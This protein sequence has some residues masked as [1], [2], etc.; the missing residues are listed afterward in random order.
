[1]ISV[2]VIL[3]DTPASQQAAR[4]AQGATQ[5]ERVIRSL[6]SQAEAAQQGIQQFLQD[7]RN[8]GK[9][10]KEQHFWLINGFSLQATAEVIQALAARPDVIRVFTEETFQAPAVNQSVAAGWDNL[11]K[12]NAP[13]LWAMG[14]RG[15]GMVVASMDTGVDYTHPELA[16]QWRGGTNSWFDPYGNH[17][18]PADLPSTCASRGHGTATMGV[19]VGKT[20]GVAPDAQWIAVKVFDDNCSATTTGIILGFQWLL[21]PDGNPSTPDAPQ[22]VNSSWGGSNPGCGPTDPTGKYVFQPALQN[23]RAAGILPVF[24]A[25][26]SGAQGSD[27]ST[28][29]GNYLEAFPVGATDS[30]DTVAP[31]SSRG[32]NNCI[33]PPLTYPELSAPGVSIYTTGVGNTYTT[34]NGTSF[35]APHVAGGLALL[36]SAFPTGLSV[37]QQENALVS[38]ALDLGPVGPDDSY[39]YGRL[40][41]LSAY[42]WVVGHPDPILVTSTLSPAVIGESGGSV[43][44]NL[45]LNQASTLPI[46]VNFTAS[47]GT[48]TEG[49]DYQLPGQVIIDSGAMQQTVTIPILDDFLPETDET[50]KIHLTLSANA[51]LASPQDVSVVIQD[52][53]IQ[54]GFAVTDQVVNETNGL[55]F[56]NLNRTGGL[57]YPAA[58]DYSFTGGT[59]VS[60]VDYLGLP[61]RI[62]FAAGETLTHISVIL[63]DD[64]QP[65]P[66]KTLTVSLSSPDPVSIHLASSGTTVTILDTGPWLILLPF[67]TR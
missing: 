54:V 41:V 16:A 58:V 38:S 52:D 65:G 8:S 40:D 42:Q 27:T 49:A 53:D 22:V 35:A 23:L 12:I 37:Q 30:L 24:S 67:V 43:S 20:V 6:Q 59:A 25:G 26:N 55:T 63:L 56:I 31:F 18:N 7:N 13:A 44:L 48:A 62:T 17:P 32:P 45:S 29:P 2:I 60:E 50:I 64:K 11:G 46:R 39:G 3:K 19:M 61:G 14:Y 5:A 21:D 66:N 15:Q 1:M 28:Y 34:L 33:A 57:S 51:I 47:N 4:A 9:I 36:L 10:V